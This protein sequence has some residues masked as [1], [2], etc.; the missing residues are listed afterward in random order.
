M[1]KPK[2][3][4]LLSALFIMTLIAIV[5]TAMTL[6]MHLDIYRTR[7]TVDSDKRYLA[8]QA[9]LFWAMDKLHDKKYTWF[10][11][12]PQGQV[13]DFPKSLQNIYP[14]FTLNGQLFDLQAKF[15]LNNLS[16]NNAIA[17]F[18]ALLDQVLP[19]KSSQERESLIAAVLYWISAYD[20][21]T[22]QDN[23]LSTYLKQTPPY[24]PSHLAFKNLSELRLVNGIDASIYQ[25]LMPFLTT[26]PGKVL[27]NV[28]TA[29]KAVLYSIKPGITT[30]QV[31]EIIQAR[32]DQGITSQNAL[33]SLFAKLNVAAGEVTIE[34]EYFLVIAETSNADFKS[35]NFSV[36]RRLKDNNGKINVSL[37]ETG[38]M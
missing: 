21:D 38:S 17:K 30:E 16:D 6:R 26:L 34:S 37:I 15:N 20:L 25:Q 28:N 31:Q 12:Y 8:S 35:V 3:S 14:G 19:Q 9:V 23:E 27:I 33:R 5:A 22:G 2:G 4:A 36:L 10:K 29:S 11:R 13:A 18:S 1:E 7:L 32:Q 24:Y